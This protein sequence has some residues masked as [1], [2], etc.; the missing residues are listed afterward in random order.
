MAP[1]HEEVKKDAGYARGIASTRE[2]S[3]RLIARSFCEGV[4]RSCG[5]DVLVLQ[6]AGRVSPGLD[7]IS[8]LWIPY[9]GTETPGE[10][11]SE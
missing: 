2:L 3:A 5:T 9:P 11:V 8:R 1:L 10:G 6:R 7:Y 4:A